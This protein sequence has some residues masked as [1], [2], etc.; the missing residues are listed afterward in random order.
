[1]KR[2]GKHAA[3]LVVIA[4]AIV[5]MGCSQPSGGGINFVD[6]SNTQ[7]SAGGSNTGNG[8]NASNGLPTVY[9]ATYQFTETVQTLAAGTD[10]TA[11]TS[12]TYVQFGDWPQSEAA[13]DITFNANP[14]S[15]GYYVGSDG[16]YYAKV[17]VVTTDGNNCE[18]TVGDVKYFKVEPIKWRVLDT[19][20]DY[21]GEN[22]SNTAKLLLAENILTANIPYYESDSNHRNGKSSNNYEDS[23]IRAYL[24]GLSYNSADANNEN[25]WSSK[26]FLQKAFTAA[27][28]AEIKTTVVNNSDDSTINYDTSNGTM[29]KATNYACDNTNDKIFLLSEYEVTKYSTEGHDAS[30]EGNSRI[31]KTTAYARANNAWQNTTAAYGGYWFLRSPTFYSNLTIRNISYKG[32][33]DWNDYY[34]F[35]ATFGVVPALSIEF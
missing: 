17:S 3:S 26:G 14:E 19:A 35:A 10:G 12:A 4:A 7:Q 32:I 24:N 16:N 8:S 30:G 20:Y 23:Q 6:G 5:M 33:A 21:D 1:M 2:T 18:Y 15:N 22:G 31:R 13:G 29:R 27:A 28:Q 34:V 9:T 11:G 25:N